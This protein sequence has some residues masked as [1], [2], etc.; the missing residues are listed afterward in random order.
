MLSHLWSTE[1][2]VFLGNFAC[3]VQILALLLGPT[4]SRGEN[5]HFKFSI[6]FA[7]IMPK[8]H[9]D[10]NM[11]THQNFWSTKLMRRNRLSRAFQTTSQ[12]EISFLWR[13]TGYWST[14]KTLKQYQFCAFSIHNITTSYRLWQMN[15]NRP[16]NPGF[17]SAPAKALDHQLL[18]S[19]RLIQK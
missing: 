5:V 17:T 3:R 11:Q 8:A 1:N 13:G 9:L 4:T 15:T 2:Q 12:K 18:Y 19:I 7:R 10:Q 16:S 14:Q 6:H